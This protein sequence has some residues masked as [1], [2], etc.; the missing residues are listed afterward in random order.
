VPLA[1]PEGTPNMEYR[2]NRILYNYGS[3]S[4]AVHF[5]ADGSVDV[6]YDSGFFRKL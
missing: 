4:V 2:T 1:L 5:L 3:Y 6:V